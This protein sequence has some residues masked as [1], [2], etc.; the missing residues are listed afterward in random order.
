MLP[1]VMANTLRKSWLYRNRDSIC[2]GVERG[3][4]AIG[5]ARKILDVREH[6]SL[7]VAAYRLGAER[8]GAIEEEGDLRSAPVEQVAP[9]AGRDV[10]R[11]AKLAGP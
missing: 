2:T 6:D 10:D 3:R 5:P 4:L 1:G 7:H 8:V 11:H 9:E